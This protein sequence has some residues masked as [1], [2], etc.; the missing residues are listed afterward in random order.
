MY[1]VESWP[2]N[3]MHG[4]VFVKQKTNLLNSL[5]VFAKCVGGMLVPEMHRSLNLAQTRQKDNVLPNLMLLLS[6]TYFN[7]LTSVTTKIGKDVN[8]WCMQAHLELF[9]EIW[10]A[11]ILHQKS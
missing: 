11:A 2:S 8:I 6:H 7:E 1:I 10:S 5:D 3:N 4:H 9:M